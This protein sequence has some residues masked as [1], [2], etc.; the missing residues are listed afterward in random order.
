M[1]YLSEIES[2]LQLSQPWPPASENARLKKYA[3]NACL[4]EGDHTKVYHTL[5]RLFPMS[6]PEFDKIIII[7]GFHRRLSCLWADLLI[8]ETPTIQSDDDNGIAELVDSTKLWYK[9]Y[10]AV[11]DA[12]RFGN[13]VFEIWID[14]EKLPHLQAVDPS[15]WFPLV[16]ENQKIAAHM[17]G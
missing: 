17:I 3:E 8:G 11:L 5:V 12:S 1:I 14:E 7:M 16:D 4:Y 15:K 2:T 13:G 10:Q 9:E 6:T